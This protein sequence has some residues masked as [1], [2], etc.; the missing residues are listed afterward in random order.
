M[1]V[2]KYNA[3]MGGVDLLDNLVA[4]YRYSNNLFFSVQVLFILEKKLFT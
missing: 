2:Q 3:G 4:C 1:M